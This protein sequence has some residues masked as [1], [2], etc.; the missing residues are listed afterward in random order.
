MNRLFSI[1]VPA[2]ALAGVKVNFGSNG[3]DMPYHI[4]AVLSA[5]HDM[6]FIKKLESVKPHGSVK[7]TVTLRDY[8][9]TSGRNSNRDAWEKFASDI[10]AMV[11]DDWY[12]NPISLHE[13]MALY[14]GAEMNFH[15]GGGTSSLCY[16]SEAPLMT[17]CGNANEVYH[18]KHGFPKGSQLP[19]LNKRQ[20]FVWKSDDYDTIRRE[21]DSFQEAA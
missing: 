1:V 19:W 7:Y 8:D 10:G 11:I 20:R 4:S 5:Y 6:G 13:R 2:C 18:R 12:K 15:V 3:Q 14:C 16:F 21:W 9:R 17:F